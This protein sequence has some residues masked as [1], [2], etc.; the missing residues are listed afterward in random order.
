M[1]AT[2]ILKSKNLNRG[3]YQQLKEQA[4]RLGKLRSEIWHTFGSING[5][6]KKKSDRTIRD[7]WLKQKRQFNV[8]ANAWKETLRY[9]FA[10]IKANREAAKEKV[11][12]VIYKKNT[13]DNKRQELYKKLKPDDWT[14]DNHLIRLMRKHWKHGH[15]HTTNQMI[16]RS[17]NYTTLQLGG[18]TWIKIPSLQKGKRITIPLNTTIEPTGTLRIILKDGFAGKSFLFAKTFAGEVEIH[19]TIDLK[20]TKTCGKTTLGTDK[21]HTE[22]FVDYEGEHYGEGLGKLLTKH[23]DS[24]KKKY[25]ARN[26]LIAIANKKLNHIKNKTFLK[27]IWVERS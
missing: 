18:H 23:S 16:V 7:Q 25:Q 15:N 14:S 9:A 8:S 19:Y 3:K 10:D 4:K 22:V 21:G 2:R 13:D 20:S 1:K 24:L 12:R 27:T 6:S 5:A 17:D 11:R 26:K